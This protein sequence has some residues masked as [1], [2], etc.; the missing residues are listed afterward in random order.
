MASIYYSQ[1]LK[2]KKVLAEIDRYIW[3]ESEKAGHEISFEQGSA[4]WLKRYAMAWI[5]RYRK[6]KTVGTRKRRL[7]VRGDTL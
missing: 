5:A 1:L 2:N 3:I 4:Q 6:R 7:L